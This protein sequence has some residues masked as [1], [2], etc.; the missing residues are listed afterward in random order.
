MKNKQPTNEYIQ[1]TARTT[2]NHLFIPSWRFI[3]QYD[4]M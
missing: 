2:Q 3:F 4:A 1:Y